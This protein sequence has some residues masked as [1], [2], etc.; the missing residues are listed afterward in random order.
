VSKKS[1]KKNKRV[2]ILIPEELYEE[3]VVKRKWKLS[4]TVREALDDV[5]S[6]EKIIFSVSPE[7]KDLYHQIFSESD[8]MDRDLEPYVRDAL[9]QYLEHVIHK[10]VG[11]LSDLKEK[12]A[13]G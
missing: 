10:K 9:A 12:L 3:I 8:C 11:A 4:G 6:Q 7:T 5:I 2:N 1:P 13:K